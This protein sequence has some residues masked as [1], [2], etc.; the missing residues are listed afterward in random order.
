MASQAF[1]S[2]SLF[3]VVPAMIHGPVAQIPSRCREWVVLGLGIAL[4]ACAS[5]AQGQDLERRA[6]A[7]VAARGTVTHGAVYWPEGRWAHASLDHR[8]DSAYEAQQ[9]PPQPPR[10]AWWIAATVF[11][12]VN[13]EQSFG[14]ASLGP[15]LGGLR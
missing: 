8:A 15:H 9:L 3:P 5:A 6:E 4:V 7:P 10:R 13:L 1:V 12:P 2:S 11:G 14:G